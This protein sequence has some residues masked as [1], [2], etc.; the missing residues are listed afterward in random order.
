[1][2]YRVKEIDGATIITADHSKHPW[3]TVSCF[4]VIAGLRNIAGI[5]RALTVFHKEPAAEAATHFRSMSWQTTDN[6]NRALSLDAQISTSAAGR[7]AISPAPTASRTATSRIAP[8]RKA[9][10]TSGPD[11]SNKDIRHPTRRPG[12]CVFGPIRTITILEPGTVRSILR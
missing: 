8:T 10:K 6:K 5:K 2:R 7:S 9:S 11:R 1:M 4:T 3:E 12:R